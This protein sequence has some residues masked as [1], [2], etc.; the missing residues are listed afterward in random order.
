MS[1]LNEKSHCKVVFLS[2]LLLSPVK[3]FFQWF[4]D[5]PYISKEFLTVKKNHF[6]INQSLKSAMLSKKLG[7]KTTD[8]ICYMHVSLCIK[9]R[10]NWDHIVGLEKSFTKSIQNSRN[11]DSLTAFISSS[12]SEFLIINMYYSYNQKNVWIIGYSKQ[13]I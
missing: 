2:K 10:E 8:T 13:C 3:F 1:L 5:I 12:F 11:I 6:E 7:T 9:R 4:L